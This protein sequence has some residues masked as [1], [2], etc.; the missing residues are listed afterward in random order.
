MRA[1]G[2]RDL[3]PL[4]GAA[5]VILTLATGSTVALAA[6]TGGRTR[7]LTKDPK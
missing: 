7:R 2:H 1:T 5:A 3:P 6:A 4:L